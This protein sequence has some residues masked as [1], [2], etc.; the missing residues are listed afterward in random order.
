MNRSC[1][2][3]FTSQWLKDD[4]SMVFKRKKTGHFSSNRDDDDI[5]YF[6]ELVNLIKRKL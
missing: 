1:E 6:E 2:S 4:F 5:Y 3:R